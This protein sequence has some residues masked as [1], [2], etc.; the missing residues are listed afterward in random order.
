[1]TAHERIDRFLEGRRQLA[2][3]AAV[4]E[5]ARPEGACG[6]GNKGA[7]VN[8]TESRT[9]LAAR[10]GATEAGLAN[11]QVLEGLRTPRRLKRQARFR[12]K[13]RYARTMGDTG[14]AIWNEQR[15][16][17]LDR[18]YLA[19]ALECEDPA[20]ARGVQLACTACGV[21]RWAPARCGIVSACEKCAKRRR[22]NLYKRL[23]RGL[24]AAHRRAMAE[25]SRAGRPRGWRPDVQLLTLGMRPDGTIAERAKALQKGWER[26]RARLHVN[27]GAALPFFRVPELTDGTEEVGHLHMHVAVIWPWRDLRELDRAWSDAMDGRANNVDVRGRKRAGKNVAKA[28]SYVAGYVQKQGCSTRSLELR[29]EWLDAIADGRRT[30][31]NSRGLLAPREPGCSCPECKGPET[32]LAVERRMPRELRCAPVRGPPIGA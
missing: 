10:V 1:M 31:S 22:G 11:L 12:A 9:D 29:A 18:G 15:A 20:N 26:F 2:A 24:G 17:A 19:R 16:D 32:V 5:A 27:D 25:W 4:R 13:A 6:L 14:R 8:P 7:T 3:E 28:A 21:I 23:A 30:Y